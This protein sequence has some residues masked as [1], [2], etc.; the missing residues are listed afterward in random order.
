MTD[1]DLIVLAADKDMQSALTGLLRTRQRALGIR[2]VT[3]DIL[4]HSRHDPA[5][6]RQGVSFLQNYAKDYR[7]GLLVFDHEGC[8]R[9]AGSIAQLRAFVEGSEAVD[10]KRR[11]QE[12]IYGLVRTRWNASA[13]GA[14]AG[15]AE[16]CS[17]SS[18]PRDGVRVRATLSLVA[19]GRIDS[20]PTQ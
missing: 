17:R 4:V 18:S 1:K 19:N 2:T 10:F 8:G 15:A 13:T 20:D 3:F 5:C 9:A 7:H 16:T 12:A 6:A 14:S 11:D